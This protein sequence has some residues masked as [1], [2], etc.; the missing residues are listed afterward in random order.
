[1]GNR[2]CLREI[3]EERDKDD[4]GLD[5]KE[6]E[7]GYSSSMV[8]VKKLDALLSQA[9]DIAHGLERSV[10]KPLRGAN[11]ALEKIAVELDV[12]AIDVNNAVEGS[13]D[14]YDASSKKLDRVSII[15]DDL[16]TVVTLVTVVKQDLS[17]IEDSFDGLFAIV[18]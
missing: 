1:M 17:D 5:I 15:S 2:R 6:I 8:E 18:R 10:T 3:A 9:F 4:K 7:L 11:A 13:K 16:A 12:L 14:K